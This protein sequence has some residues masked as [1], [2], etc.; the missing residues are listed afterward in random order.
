MSVT[1][2]KQPSYC[3]TSFESLTFQPSVLMGL[4][5]CPHET[6]EWQHILGLQSSY[7][8]RGSWYIQLA[9][10][11]S[12]HLHSLFNNPQAFKVDN[13]TRNPLYY[14]TAK[15]RHAARHCCIPWGASLTAAWKKSAMALSCSADMLAIAARCPEG[16]RHLAYQQ[17][18]AR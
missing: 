10:S 5:K 4:G 11:I 6:Q 8:S 18:A 1:P 9:S 15:T 16:Q 3:N 13:D 12:L 17:R 7:F 14:C 2:D